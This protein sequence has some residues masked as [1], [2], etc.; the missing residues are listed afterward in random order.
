LALV[1]R[2][3]PAQAAD[4]RTQCSVVLLLAMQ[5]PPRGVAL[6]QLNERPPHRPAA[7]LDQPPRNDD[8][9]PERLALS[10]PRQIDQLRLG[11]EARSGDLGKRLLERQQGARRSP[12]HGAA[13][14]AV[15][16]RRLRSGR[17]PRVPRPFAFPRAS[18]AS[19]S[20]WYA[21]R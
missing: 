2:H 17:G 5:V 13:V 3:P 15:H 9:L 21:L 18:S 12:L 4:S 7:F 1:L 16:V 19:S 14:V 10:L 20:G 6:P 11:A 8:A